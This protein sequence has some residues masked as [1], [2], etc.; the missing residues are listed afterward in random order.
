MGVGSTPPHPEAKEGPKTHHSD[1]TMRNPCPVPIIDQLEAYRAS[2]VILQSAGDL[3]EIDLKLAQRM[4]VAFEELQDLVNTGAIEVYSFGLA[5][6]ARWSQC[7]E[8][9]R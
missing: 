8:W 1:D 2:Q 3:A 5:R 7:R 6:F 4:R 9:A